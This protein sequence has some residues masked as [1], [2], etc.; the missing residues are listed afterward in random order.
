MKKTLKMSTFTI[1]QSMKWRVAHGGAR[2]TV[3]EQKVAVISIFANTF[4]I[5]R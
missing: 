5:I 2:R 3:T 4:L 1:L